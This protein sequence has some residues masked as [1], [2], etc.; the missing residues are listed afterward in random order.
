[1]TNYFKHFPC[2][3]VTKAHLFNGRLNV[4]IK[5]TGPV[6]SQARTLISSEQIAFSRDFAKTYYL[7]R[8]SYHKANACRD[9]CHLSAFNSLARHHF[10]TVWMVALSISS[11]TEGSGECDAYG[12]AHHTKSPT[13]RRRSL[14]S[15]KP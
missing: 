8:G 14:E 9:R 1:M 13:E 6:S 7:L 11:V 5:N 12:E 15:D 3:P 10:Y 2:M 4:K